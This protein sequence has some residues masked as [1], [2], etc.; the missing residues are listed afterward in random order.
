[1]AFRRATK[2]E[3]F[4]PTDSTGDI[5]FLLLIFFILTVVFTNETGLVVSLPRAEASEEGIRDMLSN[6]FINEKGMVS[7]DDMIVRPDQVAAVMSQK[8]AEN[9]FMIVAFKTDKETPYGVV[10]DVME[11]LKEA[12][13]VKVFFNTDLELPG[14]AY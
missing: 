7:I 1:M 6:V 8:L 10:S 12:N 5:A 11:G 4:I 13:A 14:V 2:K 3:A 9:P